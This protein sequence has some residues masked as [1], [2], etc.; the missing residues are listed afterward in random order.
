MSGQAGTQLGVF[1]KYW[2]PGQVKTRLAATVG[3]R[4]AAEFHQASLSA[5]LDEFRS[6]AERRVLSFTPE[7]QREAFASLAGPSWELMPQREGDLGARMRAYF[8][9]AF[10]QRS[11]RVVLI[12]ADSPQLRVASIRAALEALQQ[13]DVVLGPTTDGGYYLIGARNGLCNLFTKGDLFT[14]VDWGTTQ[15]WSQTVDRLRAAGVNW[16]ML[17]TS[18]DVDTWDDVNLLH[19][20]LIH[21]PRARL[22]ALRSVCRQCVEAGR[23]N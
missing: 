23:S 12:G 17:E 2:A 8:N 15:V 5:L 18:F 20:R 7:E 19:E 3:D 1:A 4:L 14:N 10:Q 21:D 22:A 6:C 11:Q 16:R 13:A 9:E